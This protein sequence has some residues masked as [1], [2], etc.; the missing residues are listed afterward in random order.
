MT[1]QDVQTVFKPHVNDETLN[2]GDGQTVSIDFFVV[3]FGSASSLPTY[4][5]LTAIDGGTRGYDSFFDQCK[6]E[7]LIL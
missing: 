6:S 7:G 5:E 1:V 2:I 3:L 4:A